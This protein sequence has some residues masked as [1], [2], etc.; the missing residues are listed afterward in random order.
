MN[1]IDLGIIERIISLGEFCYSR[2]HPSRFFIYDYTQDKVRMPFDG[3]VTPYVAMCDVIESNFLDFERNLEV[4]GKDIYNTKTNIKY[5][6]EK[7][8]DVESVAAQL[9]LRKNQFIN[10]LQNAKNTVVFF[11]TYN[12]YPSEIINIIQMK[13]PNLKFK[14]F[15]LDWSAY[16]TIKNRIVDDKCTYINLPLPYKTY[17]HWKDVVTPIGQ[18]YEKKVLLEF[19]NFLSE[20]NNINYDMETVFSNRTNH[21]W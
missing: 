2:L 3:C 10:A 20:I 15:T 18:I 12:K 7:N 16:P 14:I 4:R 19:L 8:L 13:Y 6:H 5:N 21:S 17:S 1:F 11:L 9:V